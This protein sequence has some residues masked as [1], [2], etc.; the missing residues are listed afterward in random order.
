MRVSKPKGARTPSITARVCAQ[1]RGYVRGCAR[2]QHQ[3]LRSRGT[4]S[5]DLVLKRS[6]ITRANAVLLLDRA[7]RVPTPRRLL[8]R[9]RAKHKELLPIVLPKPSARK[10]TTVHTHICTRSQPCHA[11]LCERVSTNAHSESESMYMFR[12]IQFGTRLRTRAPTQLEALL[13]VLTNCRPIYLGPN[14]TV[15]R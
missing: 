12:R 14:N 5:A 13:D 11:P 6:P 15:Y 4:H 7:R 8:V 1:A 3:R 10:H 9:H 2:V